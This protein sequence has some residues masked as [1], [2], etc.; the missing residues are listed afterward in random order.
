MNPSQLVYGNPG[1]GGFTSVTADSTGASG[2]TNL[3]DAMGL[4]DAFFNKTN[5]TKMLKASGQITKKMTASQQQQV[6]DDFIKKKTNKNKPCK[7]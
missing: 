3:G 4:Y 7:G 2:R 6:V 5:I 1:I